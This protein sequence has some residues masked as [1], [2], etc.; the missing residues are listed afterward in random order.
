MPA[1]DDFEAQTWHRQALQANP[2]TPAQAR[3]RI[4]SP[5]ELQQYALDRIEAA[6]E[7]WKRQAREWSAVRAQAVLEI[8][9][10]R[11]WKET[12]EL[13]GVSEPTAWNIAH[14]K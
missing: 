12:A 10:G 5:I 9:A 8:K 1:P 4:N 13:L 11:T 2:L 3:H 6:R 14:P 7:E